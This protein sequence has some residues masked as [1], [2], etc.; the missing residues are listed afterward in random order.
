MLGA[1]KI[2]AVGSVLGDSSGD[3]VLVPAAP[4][5]GSEIAALVAD[6]LLEDLEPLA[7]SIVGLDIII[8]GARKIRQRGA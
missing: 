5:I 6:T 4:S 2:L 1:E 7:R 3:G 8:G